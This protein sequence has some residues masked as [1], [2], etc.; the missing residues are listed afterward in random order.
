MANE[1]LPVVKRVP[2]L[3]GVCGTDPY[4]RMDSFLRQLESIGFAGVQNFPTVGLFDGNFRQN[5]EETGMGYRLEVD[6]IH[7]AHKMGLLTTPYA[8]N[9][10]EAS[11]MAAAGSDIIVAHMG[12]TTSG[13]IGAKTALSLDDSVARVQAITDAA[14]R[15]NPNVIMLCHG[16]PISGPKEAEYVLQRTRGVHGFYGASSMERLPVEEA[17]VKTIKQYKTISASS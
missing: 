11:V 8:F 5:L 9:E 14:A 12:L 6:V 7:K 17:I 3:A 13:S 15:V 2:V 16:G 1:V 4:R 10:A